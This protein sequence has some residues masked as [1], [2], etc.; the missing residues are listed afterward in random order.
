[1]CLCK[2][3]I[4]DCIHMGGDQS[5]MRLRNLRKHDVYWSLN[6]TYCKCEFNNDNDKRE[7]KI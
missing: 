1:M 6:V 2:I 3:C 5:N 4:P 7:N